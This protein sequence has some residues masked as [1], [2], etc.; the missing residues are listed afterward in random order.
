MTPEEL[1]KKHATEA[2]SETQGFVLIALK[3]GKFNYTACNLGSEVI[4][5]ALDLYAAYVKNKSVKAM[6]A[7]EVFNGD[8]DA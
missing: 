7:N 5:G 3:D 8:L 1:A 4:L 2:I 6:L